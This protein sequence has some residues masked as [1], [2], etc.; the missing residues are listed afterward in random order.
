MIQIP[1][2]I[3]A[4]YNPV[5]TL[6][7]DYLPS[8]HYSEIVSLNEQ[9]S[10]LQRMDEEIHR[11]SM[12]FSVDLK[13]NR[14]VHSNGIARWLGYA[15]RDFSLKDY[16]RIIH[17]THAPV[18]AYYAI[19]LLELLD[20]D[21]M[22]L[23]FMQPVCASIVALRHKNG[24]YIC[25]KREC[26]PFQLTEDNR[27]TM[28]MCRFTIIKEF[29]QENFHTRIYSTNANNIHM[30]EKLSILVKKKFA[31]HTALSTQELKILKRYAQQKNNTSE[32]IAKELAIKKSTVDTYNKRILEKAEIF[33]QR[34]FDTAK[35]AALY[36]KKSGLI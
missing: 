12:Y 33:C 27:L 21:H 9:Q 2:N 8:D 13:E 30:E 4:F 29:S 16:L 19:S 23:Q 17:P 3:H 22:R 31:A 26:T 28:Y 15:D 10:I 7:V 14:I 36:F 18:Q 20:D 11:E 34:R 35:D 5:H 6:S 32:V 1:Q 25:F 24:K